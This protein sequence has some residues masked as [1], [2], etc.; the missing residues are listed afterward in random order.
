M[1]T[2]DDDD[3]CKQAK[4]LKN[5]QHDRMR[6]QNMN[7]KLRKFWD[8]VFFYDILFLCRRSSR[9][10]FSFYMLKMLCF[11]LNHF[12]LHPFLGGSSS[13]DFEF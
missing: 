9:E 7:I 1:R 8:E 13:C 6:R 11:E 5:H 10:N 3:E 2:G 12:V 4:E